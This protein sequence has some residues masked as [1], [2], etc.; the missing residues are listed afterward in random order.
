M[1]FWLI[2]FLMW[3]DKITLALVEELSR[4]WK[5]LCITVHNTRHETRNDVEK[6]VDPPV[7]HLLKCC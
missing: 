5:I 7:Y 2:M 4:K 6:K 3:I 1:Q